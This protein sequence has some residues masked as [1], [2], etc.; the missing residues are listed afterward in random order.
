M[1]G[2]GELAYGYD[3]SGVES[4]L[5]AVK[6]DYLLR[7]KDAVENIGVIKNICETRWQGQAR[8]AF[9]FNLQAD[10]KHVSNQLEVLYDILKKEVNGIL[11]AMAEKDATLIDTDMGAVASNFA[12]SFGNTVGGGI[13][14]VVGGIADAV[15][16]QVKSDVS[17]VK[18]G[19]DTVTGT[20]SGLIDS[21]KNL[22]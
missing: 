1:A 11:A 5:E 2:I 6:S 13:T 8:D 7:A 16:D 9:L 10:A 22:F 12:A 14:G 3:A 21:A 17:Y 20:A 15:K 18:S 4:Y 19:I